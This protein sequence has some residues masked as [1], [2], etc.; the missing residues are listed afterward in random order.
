MQAAMH[1]GVSLAV[2]R[3]QRVQNHLRF[4]GRG[5]RIQIDQRLAID[6]LIQ[7]RELGPDRGSIKA[8]GLA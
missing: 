7:N 3:G 5:S 2:G 6:L 4:L 1:I 8:C